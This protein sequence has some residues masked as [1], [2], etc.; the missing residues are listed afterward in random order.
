MPAPSA[1]RQPEQDYGIMSRTFTLNPDGRFTV[2]DSSQL[3]TLCE[4]TRNYCTGSGTWRLWR[5]STVWRIALD[6]ETVDDMPNR[7]GYD[8]LFV[9]NRLSTYYIYS[10]DGDPD[11]GKVLEWAKQ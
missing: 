10:Y 8:I 11:S 5:S 1:D 2:R 3:E 6:F 4:A 7:E 9:G